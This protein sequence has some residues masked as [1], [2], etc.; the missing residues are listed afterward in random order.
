MKYC[1]GAD[2][3]DNVN[4]LLAVTIDGHVDNAS[5]YLVIN[6]LNLL[7]KSVIDQKKEEFFLYFGTQASMAFHLL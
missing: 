5:D 3:I 4:A 6:W 2:N 7:N 1:V